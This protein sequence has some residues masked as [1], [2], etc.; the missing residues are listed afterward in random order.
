M[1]GSADLRAAL[2]PTGIWAALD[3][4]PIEEVLDFA[5]A[6]EALG[7]PALWINE[8]SGREPF[9][10][11]GALSRATSRITLGLGVATIYARDAAAARSGGRTVNELAGGALRDGHRRLPPLF[12]GCPRPRVRRATVRDAGLS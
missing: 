1:T 6:V 10:F 2:G 3:G 12:G 7:F 5:A 4:I 11:L 9:A 8:G